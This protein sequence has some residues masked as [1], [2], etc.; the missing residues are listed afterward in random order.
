M[1]DTLQA[2]NQGQETISSVSI[3]VPA[4]Q[5]SFVDTN[6]QPLPNPLVLSSA[7]LTGVLFKPAPDF[8]GQV[9]FDL[10]VTVADTTAYDDTGRPAE[11][12]T[13]TFSSQV[14][15]DVIAVNDA[16]TFTG[17]TTPITGTEDQAGGIALSGL[18]ATVDDVDQS[19]TILSVQITGVPA[20]FTLASPASNS[21]QGVWTIPV[22]TGTSSFDFS[23][24]K[25]LPPLNFSGSVSLGVTVY[26]KEQSLSQP[27][28]FSDTFTVNIAPVGDN[29]DT[30]PTASASG[31]EDEVIAILLDAKTT[32]N[33]DSVGTG[34]AVTENSPETIRVVVTNVP[35]SA[36]FTLP[37]GL[38][39]GSTAIKQP[40]GSWLI[41]VNQGTL[42]N[43]AF[44]PGNANRDNW[45]GELNFS[46]RTVDNGVESASNLWDDFTVNVDV[47]PVN[48][49]PVNS[50]PGA[51]TT[52]EDQPLVINSLS[53]SDVDADESGSGG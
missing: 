18:T 16:V 50:V 23:N 45:N 51:L 32:D 29:V 49:A 40:D 44:H 17:A 12:A 48:D 31:T 33:K 43:I 24:I 1:G 9:N 47:D 30:D 19:E 3:S 27:D 2:A 42:D 37:P 36:F 8:S 21:G 5:G 15:I 25:L 28:A 53:I 39:A 41:N 13:E 6:S 46:V 35:D 26:T 20:D 11:T 14:S 22:S 10:A 38:A 34:G 7:Q 4:G 52:D